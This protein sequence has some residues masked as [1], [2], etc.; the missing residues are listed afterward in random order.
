MRITFDS[1]K[2]ERNIAERGLSFD[3]VADLEW[4]TALAEED[5]RREYGERRL[6]VLARLGDRLHAAVITYRNEAVHVIS[7]RKANDR[8]VRRYGKER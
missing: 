7:F 4:D 1:A 8:E 2:N 3:L 6:R 5:T